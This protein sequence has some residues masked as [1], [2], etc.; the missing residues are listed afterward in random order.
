MARPRNETKM[1]RNLQTEKFADTRLREASSFA[2]ATA[3]GTAPQGKMGIPR[4]LPQS[5]R[6]LVP[7]KNKAGRED[8]ENGTRGAVEAE[9]RPRNRLGIRYARRRA[10][11][12]SRASTERFPQETLNSRFWGSVVLKNDEKLKI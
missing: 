1:E 4:L 5:T 8:R 6:Y 3:D 9:R 10:C 7:Y 12:P 2:E 11:S